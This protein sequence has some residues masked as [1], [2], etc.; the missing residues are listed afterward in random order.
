MSAAARTG[1]R[2]GAV[3]VAGGTGR[4]MGEGVPKQ[5]REVAGKAVILHTLD[6]FLAFDPEISIVVVLAPGHMEHWE[7]IVAQAEDR[8]TA[9]A[10]KRISLAPGGETR[11]GSVKSGLLKMDREVEV[12]GIHDAVRPLVSHATLE[13]CYGSAA[14]SGSGVPVIEMDETVRILKPEGHSEHMDRSMLR[15]VQTPQVFRAE[16]IRKAYQ[17][18]FHPSFTDD[19]SVYE[20]LYGEVRLVKGNAENIKITTPADLILAEQ[21]L[22]GLG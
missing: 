12:I 3:I 10:A 21:L 18:P 16:M 19:A 4:R 5:Y 20:A 13:R 7:R 8:V 9:Q 6:R 14:E 1:L 22:E 15:R 2:Q 17:V 11:Y